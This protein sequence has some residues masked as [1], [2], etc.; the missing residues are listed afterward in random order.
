MSG[1]VSDSDAEVNE[2]PGK[3][4]PPIILRRRQVLFFFYLSTRNLDYQNLVDLCFGLV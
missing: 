1:F 2:P 3:K 4:V